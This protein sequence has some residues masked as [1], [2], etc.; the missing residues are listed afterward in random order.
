MNDKE[1]ND[2]LYCFQPL[3]LA[4]DKSIAEACKYSNVVINLIGA[5]Y[6]SK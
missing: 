2:C 3:D 6:E 5:E 1:K 4:D